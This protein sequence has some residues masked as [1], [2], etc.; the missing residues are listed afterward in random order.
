MSQNLTPQSSVCSSSSSSS[1]SAALWHLQW[2]LRCLLIRKHPMFQLDDNCLCMNDAYS[3]CHICNAHNSELSLQD[4]TFDPCLCDC[5]AECVADPSRCCVRPGSS[6]ILLESSCATVSH[7]HIHDPAFLCNC[8]VCVN[9]DQWFVFSTHRS[10]WFTV[11]TW[12]FPAT[13]T[14]NSHGLVE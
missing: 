10:I 7:T 6:W 5:W 2:K 14:H 3:I 4:V 9:I 8:A 12:T 13:D 1:S 11:Y